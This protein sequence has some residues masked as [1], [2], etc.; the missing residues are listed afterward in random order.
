MPI[1]AVKRCSDAKPTK[2]PARLRG[3]A[4]FLAWLALGGAAFLVEPP[5]LPE[6]LRAALE[7]RTPA[8][9]GPRLVTLE[10]LEVPLRLLAR[11][12][13]VLR[14]R[15]ARPKPGG[16]GPLSTGGLLAGLVLE[17]PRLTGPGPLEARAARAVLAGGRLVLAGRVR[18]SY[19]GRP[20]LF[21][22]DLTIAQ[23]RDH[24]RSAGPLVL[25]PASPD[26]GRGGRALPSFAGSLAALLRLAGR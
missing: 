7:R 13:F 2:A 15:R 6:A 11:D 5:P 26:S 21:A 24:L 22:P 23:A 9:P 1:S 17:R 10:D 16:L 19:A 25:R 18:V 20:L 12:G 14:A 4:P 8:P 3:A